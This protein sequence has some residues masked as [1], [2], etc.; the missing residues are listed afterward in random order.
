M[1]QESIAVIGCG[2][3]GVAI[4]AD[5]SISGKEVTIIKTSSVNDETFLKIK[6]NDNKVILKENGRYIRTQIHKLTKDLEEIKNCGVIFVTVQSLYHEQL[7]KEISGHLSTNQIVVV[8][9]SYMS[10]FY[11]KKYCKELPIIAET[12]GPY[13]E[14]R[15]EREDIENEIVFRVGCRLTKSPLSVFQQERTE[16]CMKRLKELYNGFSNE[17]STIECGLLNPNMVLHTVSAVM[18]I[19][20]IEYSEGNFCMYREAYSKKN[21]ATLKIMFSLDEEK[22]IVLKRLGQKPVDILKA[23]G[24][25]GDPMESFFNYSESSDRAISPTSVKSRYI[26][27]DVPEGLVLLE[28]IANK[29]GVKVPIASAIIDIAGSA[30]GI[31]FRKEGRTIEKL[32]AE[33]FIKDYAKLK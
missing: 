33:D 32:N 27:E 4:A 11:F 21:E 31:D 22:K 15:I 2:N 1:K 16:E 18:S 25:L 19:P 24:F 9:C 10:S 23:G 30:L 7:V 13:L 29:V 6:E 28:S 12:T 3:V 26:T 14:G 8:V 20:R 5:L 17:Y